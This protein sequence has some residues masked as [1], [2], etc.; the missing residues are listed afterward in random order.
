MQDET[1]P[2]VEVEAERVASERKLAALERQHQ[3][4]RLVLTRPGEKILYK[5]NHNQQGGTKVLLASKIRSRCSRW[6]R[7]CRS[8]VIVLRRTQSTSLI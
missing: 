6:Y 5:S 3:Q 1:V 8:G 7:G 2:L 4:V